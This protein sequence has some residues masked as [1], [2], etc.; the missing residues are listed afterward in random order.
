MLLTELEHRLGAIEEAIGVMFVG[1]DGSAVLVKVVA[2]KPVSRG[3]GHVAVVLAGEGYRKDS[4]A[5]HGAGERPAAVDDIDEGAL[6]RVE[7]P[8]DVI[9]RHID[10]GDGNRHTRVF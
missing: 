8:L 9:Q 1:T 10:A 6:P 3:A 5:L 2:Q 4:G 7:T